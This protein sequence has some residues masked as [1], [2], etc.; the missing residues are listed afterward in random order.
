MSLR[1]ISAT[2]GTPAEVE[3]LRE[4]RDQL[5]REREEAEGKRVQYS[6]GTLV[7][8]GV[9]HFFTPKWA[10]QFEVAYIWVFTSD[11]FEHELATTLDGAFYF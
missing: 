4:A 2:D 11:V 6:A 1:R 3:A 9:T 8:V 10:L 7:D 5:A